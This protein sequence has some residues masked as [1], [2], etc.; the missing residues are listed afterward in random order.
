MTTGPEEGLSL[1]R[2]HWAAVTL[3]LGL[4]VT[5]LDAAMVIV[6]LP[7]IAEDLSVPASQVIWVMTSYQLT[8]ACLLL[9]G[10]AIGE[11]F[12]LWT[13]YCAGLGLFACGALVSGSSGTLSALLVGRV[14]QGIGAAGVHS[15]SMALLRHS[16]PRSLFGKAAGVNSSV[17]GLSMAA[18]PSVGALLLLLGSWRLIFLVTLPV[19]LINFALAAWS[20]PRTIRVARPFD[21]TSALLTAAAILSLVLGL[22]DIRPDDPVLAHPSLLLALSVVLFSLLVWRLRGKENPVF[23]VDLLRLRPIAGSLAASMCIFTAQTATMVAFPFHL[24]QVTDFSPAFI[25]LLLTPWPVGVGLVASTAGNLSDRYSTRILCCSGATVM[26]GGL[27]LLFLLPQNPTALDI[28]WRVAICGVGFGL[29]TTPNN[30]VAMLNAPLQRAGA[31]GSLVASARI[32]G[33]TLGATFTAVAYSY[34]P[35]GGG[36]MAFALAAGLMMIA[37]SLCLVRKAS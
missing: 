12:G 25:G 14:L 8:M 22:N 18:G 34:A 23:P 9:P 19:A 35:D 32:M 11:K 36:Q 3:G 27:V 2:R 30:R 7:V 24:A 13:T 31:A 5:I 15:L 37:L 10:A 4:L 6:L 29:F 16:Y 33:Q 17:V 26:L 21:V 20:L 1:P 28:L